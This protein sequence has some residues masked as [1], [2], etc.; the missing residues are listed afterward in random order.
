MVPL[1]PFP[2]LLSTASREGRGRKDPSSKAAIHCVGGSVM[3]PTPVNNNETPLQYRRHSTLHTAL[4]CEW[5]SLNKYM[6]NATEQIVVKCYTTLLTSCTVQQQH[7]KENTNAFGKE[8][9]STHYNHTVKS[10]IPLYKEQFNHSQSQLEPSSV[11]PISMSMLKGKSC[12]ECQWKAS[13][14]PF[15]CPL[16]TTSS[17]S[18][19]T[20]FNNDHPKG[21]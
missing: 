19:K 5:S 2:M 9:S 1:P 7:H 20:H 17:H 13:A 12:S 14:M 11:N 6:E 3:R 18:Y 4:Q 10:H 8:N 15:E 16:N 21:V